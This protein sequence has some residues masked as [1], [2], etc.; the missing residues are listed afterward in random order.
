MINSV[1]IGDV[2]LILVAKLPEPDE[3]KEVRIWKERF[4]IVVPRKLDLSDFITECTC[5]LETT[6]VNVSLATVPDFTMTTSRHTKWEISLVGL[7][8]E[9][10]ELLTRIMKDLTLLEHA[11]VYPSRWQVG[12]GSRRVHIS[13]IS[14][15]PR[16]GNL[17]FWRITGTGAGF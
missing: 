15:E 5:H 1:K 7:T 2:G 13:E 4:G 9:L 10:T 6:S 11:R 17:P 3:I 8:E 16:T 12:T 14:V